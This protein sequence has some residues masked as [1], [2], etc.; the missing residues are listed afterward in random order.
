MSR[1]LSAG[2]TTAIA[3]ATY[4]DV[5]FLAM[6][7]DDWTERACTAPYSIWFDDDGTG[8]N[9][10]VGVGSLG[11]ISQTEEGSEL[12]AYGISAELTGVDDA[13]LAIA[14]NSKYQG[15]RA[16]EWIGFLDEGHN[17][18]SDPVL[19]FSGLMDTMPIELGEE[20]KITLNVEN[21][22]SRWENP[23]PRNQRFT[24]ADQQV[25]YRGDLG[26]EFASVSTA[27]EVIWGKS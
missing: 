2:V 16:K 26:L 23:N 8:P 20:A 4:R 10:F 17:L 24:S 27:R 22:L 21:I 6:Y 7:G 11:K 25:R 19:I 12:R 15:R 5:Y 14:L 9:E 18:I 1:T 13:Q 3:A